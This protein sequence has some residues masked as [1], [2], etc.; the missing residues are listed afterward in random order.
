VTGLQRRFA[1]PTL[2]ALLLVG[3]AAHA[4]VAE[5]GEPPPDF[6]LADENGDVHRLSEMIG[7]PIIV[8]FTHNMCHYCTQVIAFLKRAHAEYDP[9]LT[10]LTINVWAKGGELI[11]RYKEQFGLPF[12]MLAGKDPDLLRN[13]E[14][15]YVPIL[16][17]IG[18]DGRV[19]RIDHHYILE[20]DF[21]MAV[22]KI[23]SAE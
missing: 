9:N 8:Y 5:V 23:V 16:V 15:N 17:F 12:R 1:L 10:I 6:A 21:Q 3:G 22:E 18:R 2:L 19:R 11:R 13:Y 7:Q 20:E 4:R 14:V